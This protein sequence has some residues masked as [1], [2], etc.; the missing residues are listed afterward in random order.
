MQKANEID[1]NKKGLQIL[2]TID[3]QDNKN[4]LKLRK[5]NA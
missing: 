5:H 3:I 2:K 1:D 4:L